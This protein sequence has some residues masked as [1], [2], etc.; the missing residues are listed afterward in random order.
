MLWESSPTAITLSWTAARRRR[1]SRL[2]PVGVLVFVHQ[3]VPE[4]P[5]D[6]AASRLVLP[7][8]GRQAKQ[9]VV[10]VHQVPLPLRLAVQSGDLE[11][12]VQA[13]K[14]VGRFLLHGRRDVLFAV[15][16]P[17]EEVRQRLFFRKA[18]GLVARM[19][20]LAQ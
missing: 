6:G 13:V 12:V 9:E 18:D 5:G 1:I 2:D 3:D 7:Q 19:D 4:G 15:G 14:E 10:V 16:R 8:E 17:A 20:L 11:D